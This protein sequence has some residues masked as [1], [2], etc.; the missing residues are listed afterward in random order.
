M[1]QT[2]VNEGHWIGERGKSTFASNKD[3]V[4]KILDD[5][6]LEGIDYENAIPDFSPVS[7]G[8]MKITDMGI[9]RNANF[10][11][12]DE[13]LVRKLEKTRREIVKFRKENKLAWHELN[14]MT[15]M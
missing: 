11:Q 5:I 15:S 10:R 9:D 6:S 14:D 8:E 7:K 3:E 2:P 12:A 13:L 4:R 1:N